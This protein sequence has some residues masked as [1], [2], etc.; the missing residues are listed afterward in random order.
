MDAESVPARVMALRSIIGRKA[1]MRIRRGVLDQLEQNAASVL[2]VDKVDLRATGTG[3]WCII[4]H[5]YAAV[6]QNL[7]CGPD[8]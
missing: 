2:G 1:V 3:S 5:P 4:K 6:T 8:I 7:G